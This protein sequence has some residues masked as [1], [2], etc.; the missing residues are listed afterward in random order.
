MLVENIS[1]TKVNS[2]SFI[3]S[4]QTYRP[5]IEALKAYLL[6]KCYTY[7]LLTSN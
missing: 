5:H 4:A 6:C 2:I 7:T 1:T 3:Q